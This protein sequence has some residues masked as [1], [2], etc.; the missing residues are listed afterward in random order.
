[1]K[2]LIAEDEKIFGMYVQPRNQ[3]EIR[4]NRQRDLSGYTAG[5]AFLTV[6]FA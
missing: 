5:E 6:R 1:M 2:L 4:N 3:K